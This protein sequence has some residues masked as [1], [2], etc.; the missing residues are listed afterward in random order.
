MMLC[1]SGCFFA[2]ADCR[3]D[4][5]VEE[6][7]WRINL[8][9]VATAVSLL[10]WVAVAVPPHHLAEEGVEMAEMVEEVADSGDEK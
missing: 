9:Q 1:W 7:S 4:S 2:A 3:G 8:A 10:Q 6:T 5:Q